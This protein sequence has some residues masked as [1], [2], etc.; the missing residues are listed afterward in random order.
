[1]L[2]SILVSIF[3]FVSSA[4]VFCV[5]LQRAVV[6]C[7][8][9]NK[10]SNNCLQVSVF[11][12]EIKYWCNAVNVGNSC[13]NCQLRN[14]LIV[15]VNKASSN[16]M[17]GI[18]TAT[19]SFPPL[20]ITRTRSQLKATCNFLGESKLTL[21]LQVSKF[22]H[23]FS[24]LIQYKTWVFTTAFTGLKSSLRLPAHSTFL[25][26]GGLSF[27]WSSERE[28]RKQTTGKDRKDKIVLLLCWL[29]ST[30]FTTC[31][32]GTASMLIC[33]ENPDVPL[34]GEVTVAKHL[35]RCTGLNAFYPHQHSS[36]HFEQ[37]NSADFEAK[38]A[39]FATTN[40]K[41]TQSG[42]VVLL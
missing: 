13:T 26:F 36:L 27:F 16:L 21:Y 7:G 25:W 32:C 23:G 9:K 33:M 11:L 18:N 5:H 15:L 1:M 38:T 3:V 8:G 39:F 29:K 4:L 30:L 10:L 17:K 40:P 28:R 22:N 35:T 12:W 6:C 31:S 14:N 41:W 19:L 2:S 20:K 42:P 37:N 24:L 34:A